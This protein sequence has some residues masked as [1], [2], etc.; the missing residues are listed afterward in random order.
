MTRRPLPSLP[1][2]LLAGWVTFNGAAARAESV[3][4]SDSQKA[5]SD[6]EFTILPLVGGDTD[7]GIGGG[8]IASLARVDP[9]REPYL[10]RIE[11]AGSVTFKPKEGGV[12]VPYL[13]DYLLLSLPHVIPNQVGLNV[14]VSYTHERDISYF[15]LGNASTAPPESTEKDPYYHYTWTH[16]KVDVNLEYERG[17]LRLMTGIAYTHNSLEI[18]DES[19]IRDDSQS[20]NPDVRRLTAITPEHGVAAFTYGV[21]WDTRDDEVTPEQGRYHTLRFDFAPGATDGIPYRWL[22]NN[23]ALREYVPLIPE[24]LQL[25]VRLV[26]DALVGQPPF[27]E[28]ARHDST[29][30]IGGGKGVRGFP[31]RRYHG[32]LKLFSNLELR[33]WVLTFDLFDKSNRLG[34]VGFVDAGRVWAD[35]WQL[36]ELDGEGLGLKVGYGGGLRVAAGRS[37]VLRADIATSANSGISGYLAAG[38]IF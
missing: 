12:Q 21:G 9:N 17:H 7:V 28:L 26:V 13:D 22:R 1:S 20:P 34:F 19:L 35:Y 30:A 27:Y 2:F 10:W 23:L 38:H 25:A 11:S 14:R 16:P 5:E 33:Y 6:T 4:S 24:R 29:N 37:F 31:A 18:P 32:M 36:S 3:R 8:Y 15:G